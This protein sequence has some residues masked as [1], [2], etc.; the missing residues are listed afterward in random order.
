M[1]TILALKLALYIRILSWYIEVVTWYNLNMYE[2]VQVN[3]NVY[4]LNYTYKVAQSESVEFMASTK[5][6][7]TNA[8]NGMVSIFDYL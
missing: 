5:E 8:I 3:I 6:Y 4:L 1:P 7:Q 2:N